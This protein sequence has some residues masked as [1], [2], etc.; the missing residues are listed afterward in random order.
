[1]NINLQLPH[2]APVDYPAH[3]ITTF[4][5]Y[6]V[7]FGQF[8]G[9][10]GTYMLAIKYI[11]KDGYLSIPAVAVCFN[12]A[13]EFS[14]SFIF[15]PK[16]H[17]APIFVAWFLLDLYIGYSVFTIGWKD[18]P[19]LSR[20]VFRF[21][22]AATMV[23][24]VAFCIVGTYEFKDYEG[25]YLAYGLNLAMSYLFINMLWKRKSSIGQSMYIAVLK[26]FGTIAAN[27]MSAIWFPDRGLLWLFY[28]AIFA[29]DVT[30][31]VMLY[32]QIKSEGGA[33]WDWN[34]PPVAA[35][36]ERAPVRVSQPVGEAT[37]R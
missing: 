37:T 10:G 19:T 5:L 26:C 6:L 20:K 21:C 2:F 22:M 11:R 27:V 36:P 1:M 18:F 31:I 15:Y 16:Y 23:F 7:A 13:W 3:N 24:A 35:Q 29:L 28:F 4:M 12:L 14:W 8:I 33:P 9:W 17:S 34:R 30:Y 25:E 32:R